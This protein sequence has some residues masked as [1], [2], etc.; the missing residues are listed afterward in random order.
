MD[1]EITKQ[2]I[3]TLVAD[4]TDELRTLPEN[5]QQAEALYGALRRYES[6]LGKVRFL[7]RL[8]RLAELVLDETG[9]V[10]A[11][12]R[13]A[14]RLL[15]V[16]PDDRAMVEED[17]A[18]DLLEGLVEPA[19]FQGQAMAHRARDASADM[20]ATMAA[21]IGPG[22]ELVRR[23]LEVREREIAVKEKEV[24]IAP[25]AVAAALPEENGAR[26]R[27]DEPSPG[28]ESA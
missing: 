25:V 2:Y 5:R 14:T 12:G 9:G 3:S 19:A 23:L 1:A 6:M 4:L 18:D 20:M 21:A 7:R 16:N 24:G 10:Q 15:P 17:I 28:G 8:S 22:I 27:Q 11:P 26:L 13:T